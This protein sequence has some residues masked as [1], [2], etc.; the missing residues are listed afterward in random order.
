MLGASSTACWRWPSSTRTRVLFL[1]TAIRIEDAY[2]DFGFLYVPESHSVDRLLRRLGAVSEGTRHM[3]RMAEQAVSRN[4]ADALVSLG[5]GSCIGLAL[6]DQ[7]AGVAGL[8]AHRAARSRAARGGAAPGE[9][10]RHRRAAPDRAVVQLRR[11]TGRGSRPC[12]AAAR[13]CS[14]RRPRRARCCRSATATTTRTL[15]AL[16]AARIP[17]RGAGHGR[18]Q[19]PL[20]RGAT[21]RPARCSCAASARPPRKL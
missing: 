12:S 3:V 20:G 4:R 11:A 5:L 17:V 14:R 6:V 21:S 19:R 10:R 13:T 15:A 1:K 16:Q 18:L 9:V 8:V 2:C 7:D